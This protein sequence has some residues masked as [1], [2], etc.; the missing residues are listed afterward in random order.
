M[1]SQ[2]L[3]EFTIYRMHELVAAPVS[4]QT[5][6]VRIR[7]VDTSGVHPEVTEFAIFVEDI[8]DLTKR[9]GVQRLFSQKDARLKSFNTNYLAANHTHFA[10]AKWV[11]MLFFQGLIRNHDFE[12]GHNLKGIVGPAGWEPI[13]YDFD[14]ADLFYIH[15]AALPYGF[16]SLQPYTCLSR[17][18]AQEIITKYRSASERMVALLDKTKL[19][20][21][22][23]KRVAIRNIEF[24]VKYF[25][26]IPL[27]TSDLESCPSG[28]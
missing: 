25:D 17:R 3:N 9:L 22:D 5:R 10:P 21:G 4:F 28:R 11:E 20:Q 2:L 7:Y 19:V 12:W 14:Y 16:W 18:Q 15:S 26:Q 8:E 6:L 1:Q 24:F 27:P 13:P 23:V